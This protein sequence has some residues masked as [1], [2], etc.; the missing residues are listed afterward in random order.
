MKT[1]GAKSKWATVAAV[2]GY[3]RR[4]RPLV[5]ASL[6]LSAVGV[7]LALY[8]PVLMGGAIDLLIAGQMDFYGIFAILAKIAAAAAATALCQWLAGIVNNRIALRVVR[9]IRRDAFER[10]QILPL[11]YID[12]HPHGETLSR[13]VVDADQFANGLLLGFSQIFS[14]ALSIVFT[15]FFMLSLQPGIALIVVLLTPIS[16]LVAGFIARRTYD[17]FK[18]QSELRS[19]QTAYIDEMIGAQKTVRAFSR[20]DAAQ[21]RFDEINGR[22]ESASVRAIF[23]SSITNPA[24]RFVNSLIYAAVALSGALAVISG[25]ISVGGI[26]A[27]LS[28]ANQYTKPF[29]EISGVMAELQNALACAARIFEFTAEEPQPPDAEDA[30][31]L[32]LARGDVEIKQISF[33][34]T[35]NQKLIEDF[36]LKVA[37]GKRVAIVGPTGCG[38]TTLI[39]LLM[40]FYDVKG[41]R[42]S[43]DGEDIR[44]ITRQSLRQNFGMV[45]QDTW[46]CDGTIRDNIKM[47]ANAGD[48]EIEAAA[49]AAHA[50]D[51]IMQ[52]PDGYDTKIKGDGGSLSQGQRQMLCIA[53]VMLRFPPMLIL[54]E[55]TSFVDTRT[56]MM[57]QSAFSRLM[58]GKTSFVV[59][60]R[61]STIREADLI[62]VMRDGGVVEQGDHESLLKLGGFYKKLHESQF[63]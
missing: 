20:E 61:L 41:G 39:N 60:H 59:A 27:F 7:A 16:L 31:V 37:P 50:H 23:F 25:R 21:C 44:N 55:A 56:E 36:S 9:D 1:D 22:L 35:Q 43:V 32:D 11:G 47:G 10:L 38:K 26:A 45:L 46:L 17:M 8:I 40:R 63:L 14:G 3:I 49:K 5:L 58:R 54:D 51:F 30:R 53:R 57:I 24:T 48:D 2:W 13:I 6:L 42:I 19:E 4:F 34:Y 62:L 18:K 29:N 52:L 28:Y 15:L 12:S 33:S